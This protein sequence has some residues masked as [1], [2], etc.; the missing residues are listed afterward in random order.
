MNKNFVIISHQ[1]TGSNMVRKALNH[2]SDIHCGSEILEKENNLDLLLHEMNNRKKENFCFLLKYDQIE[3][4]T[5]EFL[6][7]YGFKIIH[8]KRRNKLKSFVSRMIGTGSNRKVPVVI[9]IQQAKDTINAISA[10]ESKIDVWF[11]QHIKTDLFYEDVVATGKIP[12]HIFRFM[13]VN[14]QS[15]M[16]E[17]YKLNPDNLEQCVTNYQDVANSF[18]EYI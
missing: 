5:K 11:N 14:Y 1:R 15:C 10:Y 7:Q 17:D 12:A 3:N 16:L 6:N 9:N 8:L 4:S 18:P 13:D 2:H